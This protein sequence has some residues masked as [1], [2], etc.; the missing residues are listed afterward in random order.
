MV[1]MQE[2]RKGNRYT[3]RAL[4]S[5]HLLNKRKWKEAK[6]SRL[7]GNNEH[8]LHIEAVQRSQGIYLYTS[9]RMPRTF[10]N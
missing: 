8:N 10:R 1:S 4:I 7:E 3:Q 9:S 2:L 5:R 6:R